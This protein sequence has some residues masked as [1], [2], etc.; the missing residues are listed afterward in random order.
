MIYRMKKNIFIVFIVL[1][2]LLILNIF[3][4]KSS[5]KTICTQLISNGT[6]ITTNERKFNNEEINTVSHRV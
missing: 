6:N 1:I 4:N 3:D 2:L 5:K